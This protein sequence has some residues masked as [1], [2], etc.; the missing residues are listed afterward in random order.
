MS[1]FRFLLYA[2]LALAVV[3]GVKAIR[4]HDVS[5][6]DGQGAARV[7]ASWDAQKAVDQAEALR[8]ERERSAEQ[9]IKFRNA[10]RITDDQDKKATVR[11]RRIAAGSAVAARLRNTIDALNRRDLSAGGSDPQS[12]ALA[13]EAAAARELLG[14][15]TQA[16]RDLA[17]AADELRDQVIGLQAYAAM[18]QKPPEQP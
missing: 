12:A 6:G 3:L 2:G 18:C 16:H 11:E 9:L 15:C 8:L 5:V 17:A 10:E 14:S 4:A 7:Q 1:W 13:G